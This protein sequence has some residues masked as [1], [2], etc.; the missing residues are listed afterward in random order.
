MQPRK[1]SFVSL[2]TQ[3]SKE[4]KDELNQIIKATSYNNERR[5]QGYNDCYNGYRGGYRSSP[6]C[7][8]N[9]F[10]VS[11]GFNIGCILDIRP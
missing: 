8:S 5:R 11:I 2:A 6:A 10:P 9:N 3:T 4:V 7:N 1:W